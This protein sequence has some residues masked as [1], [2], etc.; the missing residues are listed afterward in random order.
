VSALALLWSGTSTT[1]PTSSMQKTVTH[2]AAV[3]V[4]ALA[5]AKVIA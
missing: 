3:L 4:R 2:F 5:E 1:N